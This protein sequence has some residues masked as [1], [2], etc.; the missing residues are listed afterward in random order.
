MSALRH[1]RKSGSRR[2]RRALHIF[3][4]SAE[5]IAFGIADA[6]RRIEHLLGDLHHAV[7]QRATSSQ[8]YAAGQLTIPTRVAN[9]IIHMHEN[10][11]SARLQNVTKDLTRE[12]SRRATAD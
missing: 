6:H 7:E 11:L 1:E 4:Q 9:F 10:F 12:L 5:A 3:D 2:P 8:D